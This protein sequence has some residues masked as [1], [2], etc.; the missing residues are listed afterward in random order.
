VQGGCLLANLRNFV[1]VSNM[2]VIMLGYTTPGDGGAGCFFWQ[3]GTSFV[4]DNGLSTIVPYGV[5]DGAWIRDAFL[6]T[7]SSPFASIIV[8]GTSD[9][10]GNVLMQSALVVD[11]ATSL[12]S[13]LSV[14]GNAQFLA[15]VTASG[16]LSVG[17]SFAVGTNALFSDNVVVDGTL[18]VA[19]IAEFDGAISVG[20]GN[21]GV[22]GNF[23]VTGAF[24]TNGSA[25]I[26]GTIAFGSVTGPTITTGAG[27]P[28]ATQPK[29]SIYMR[30]GGGVGSTLYVT[31]GGGV[32]NAVAGV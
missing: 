21:S 12:M 9:L 20:A 2:T 13:T 26:G 5:I 10:Q 23:A 24:Q 14:T 19:G 22:A 28:S 3:N 1:G 31:Q 30:T 6:V 29:G 15:N 32:W 25:V 27:A 7:S 17:G 18:E 11:G 16:G 8:S 4:D